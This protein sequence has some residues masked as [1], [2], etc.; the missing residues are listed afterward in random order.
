MS[1]KTFSVPIQTPLFRGQF[2]K[3]DST[4]SAWF[5][6]HCSVAAIYGDVYSF[7]VRKH[8]TILDLGDVGNILLLTSLFKD[9][10]DRHGKNPYIFQEA[11]SVNKDQ[12]EVHRHSEFV[13][14]QVI[15][16]FFLLL[17]QFYSYFEVYD[18]FGATEL[19]PSHHWEIFLPFPANK[20]SNPVH[21][22]S[23]S[24][25]KKRI[26]KLAKMQAVKLAE[27]KDARKEAR[28]K[29]YA[30]TP[31]SPPKMHSLGSSVTSVT[32]PVPSSPTISRILRF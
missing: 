17:N 18:G 8:L 12:T 32:S 4:K 10:A 31:P 26:L 13:A 22:A 15:V 1:L 23:L 11:F 25:E 16:E 29:I 21:V 7:Q 3:P 9:Y 27:K 2:T 19:K 20:I 5:A 6:N 30:Q 14:D 24:F 28:M